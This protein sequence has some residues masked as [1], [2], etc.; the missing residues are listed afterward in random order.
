M[1]GHPTK[2]L[3][4]ATIRT[5]LYCDL[6]ISNCPYSSVVFFYYDHKF[7]PDD[8]ERVTGVLAGR[9]GGQCFAASR[10]AEQGDDEAIPRTKS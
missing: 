6:Q 8:V 10:G 9:L 7:A 3:K 5:T 2:L 4:F 1:Y